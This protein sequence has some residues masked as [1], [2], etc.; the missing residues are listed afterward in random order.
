MQYRYTKQRLPRGAF[1][2]AESR[3]KMLLLKNVSSLRLTYQVRL[4]TLRASD[5][6]KKLLIKV[7]RDCRIHPSLKDFASRFAEVVQ[8]EEV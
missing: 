6:S 3:D 8:I 5:A 2:D 7:P 1:P 4:L